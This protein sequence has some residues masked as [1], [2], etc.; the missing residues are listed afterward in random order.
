MKTLLLNLGTRSFNERYTLTT[1]AIVT[2]FQ[3]AGIKLVPQA[4]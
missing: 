1:P 2:A 4:E 3:Q